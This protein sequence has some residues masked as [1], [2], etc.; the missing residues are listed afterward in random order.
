MGNLLDFQP[1]KNLAER[2]FSIPLEYEQFEKEVAKH[3]KDGKCWC[4]ETLVGENQR[5]AVTAE[6]DR[7]F[8]EFAEA[9]KKGVEP[10]NYPKMPKIVLESQAMMAAHHPHAHPEDRDLQQEAGED[11]RSSIFIYS[12]RQNAR[13]HEIEELVLADDG[14]FSEGFRES[15]SYC[16]GLEERGDRDKILDGLYIEFRDYLSKHGNQ[17]TD[18]HMG[19]VCAEGNR[20]VVRDLTDSARGTEEV[21]TEKG[22]VQIVE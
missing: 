17:Y 1:S 22:N 2:I 7:Y 5:E 14:R 19:T 13:T 18:T 12:R 3:Q 21:F 8:R 10:E 6:V 20:M 11:F 4:I 9:V 16:F 15:L